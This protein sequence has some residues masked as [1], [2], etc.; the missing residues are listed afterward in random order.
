MYFRY[1]PWN[2]SSADIKIET[3]VPWILPVAI[4]KVTGSLSSFKIGVKFKYL[5]L[6]FGEEKYKVVNS[7]I[8]NGLMNIFWG[9]E[10]FANSMV[11]I[12]VFL[13]RLNSAREAYLNEFLIPEMER[14]AKSLGITDIRLCWITIVS[15]IALGVN[16]QYLVIYWSS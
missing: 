1:V 12:K 9:E 7:D 15:S 3:V 6:S 11:K 14:V 5:F 16:I 10:K 13:E 2:A 8:S 4:K